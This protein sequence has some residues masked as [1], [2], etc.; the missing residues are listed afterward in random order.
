MKLTACSKLSLSPIRGIWTRAIRIEHW[1][2][3][4]G[5]NHTRHVRSRFSA[6][7]T[8]EPMFRILYLAQN[9]QVALFEVGELL[10]TPQSPVGANLKQTWVTIPLDIL[11]HYVADLTLAGQQKLIGTSL[12]ELTGDWRMYY[13]MG[14]APTQEL[15]E[16]LYG[17]PNLEGA[18]VPSAKAE[19]KNLIVFPDKL[20]V[21]SSIRYGNPTTGRSESLK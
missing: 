10:G 5:T 13:K 17:V 8:T 6:G 14:K 12:Q 19:S 1:K 20:N 9:A 11:L 18:F 21:L 15:G 7:S 3:R 2:S 16:A 4:L